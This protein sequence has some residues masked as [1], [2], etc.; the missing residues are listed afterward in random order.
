LLEVKTSKNKL[1]IAAPPLDNFRL[2]LI[3]GNK[4]DQ[5]TQIMQVHWRNKGTHFEDDYEK[6]SFNMFG[7]SNFSVGG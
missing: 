2:R 7:I 5:D 6:F 4:L 3:I 1:A